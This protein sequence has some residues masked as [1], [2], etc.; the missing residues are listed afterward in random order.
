MA[1]GDTYATLDELKSYLNLSGQTGLDDQMM[2]ALQSATKEINRTC[3]RQFNKTSVATARV[4]EA[5]DW[6]HCYVDDFWTTSGF[7]L[8]TDLTG[9]GTF[10]TTWATGDYELF[11]LNALVDGE[12]WPYDELRR[13]GAHYFPLKY[14]YDLRGTRARVQ[15]TAQWGW[16]DVPA[17][18][19]QACLGVAAENF[20]LKD[21][22]LGVAGFGEF[23]VVRVRGWSITLEKKLKKYTKD[24]VLCG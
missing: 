5:V 15:V 6:H 3:H 21:A 9:D 24:Q 20:Q 18:I 14:A 17:P 22:P 12:P 2:D 16:P 19:K 7:V 1:L 10:E 8:A 11:P 13:S 23:G 4:F